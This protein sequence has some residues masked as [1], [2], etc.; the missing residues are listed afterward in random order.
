MGTELTKSVNNTWINNANIDLDPG[1]YMITGQVT[2]NGT[3][4]AITARLVHNKTS[5][6]ARQ[7]IYAKD[8]NTYVARITYLFYSADAFSMQLQA[9]SSTT[10]D[11]ISFALYADKIG[12]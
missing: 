1:L 10:F 2:I 11:A 8:S 9:W 3:G 5:D 7:S 12:F 6:V 4:N